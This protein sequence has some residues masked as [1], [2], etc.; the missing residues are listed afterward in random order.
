MQYPVIVSKKTIR[1]TSI[2]DSPVDSPVGMKQI[3]VCNRKFMAV[4]VEKPRSQ[5]TGVNRISKMQQV[6]CTGKYR[7]GSFRL[8]HRL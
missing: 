7:S 5:A 8:L 1:S 3:L 2:R 4:P 6:K